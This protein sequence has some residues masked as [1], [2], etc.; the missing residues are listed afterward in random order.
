MVTLLST[1]DSEA[2]HAAAKL[3]PLVYDELKRL[4]ASRMA[5][6]APGQ[7]LQPTALVHEAYLEL[8]GDGDPGWNGKAH[9]FG[10]AAQAMREILVDQARHK[11]RQKR[12]GDR[13]REPLARHIAAAPEFELPSVDMLALDEAMDRL[14]ADHP[15]RAQVVM[16][17]FFAG[18]T[19]E[20]IAELLDTSAR[21]I[22]RD[23]RFARAWLGDAL[24]GPSTEPG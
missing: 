8:V 1:L 17:R 14:S 4:A 23:W 16:L 7:T 10:A 6:L 2:P 22:E 20:Q 15:R 13:H 5:H 21:T 3:L 11:S 18:L 19:A 24:S 12:G 9:F